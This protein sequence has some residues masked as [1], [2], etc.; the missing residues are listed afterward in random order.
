MYIYNLE[1]VALVAGGRSGDNQG[2]HSLKKLLYILTESSLCL[3]ILDLVKG[4][5]E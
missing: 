5:I 3:W 1:G 2:I 4:L